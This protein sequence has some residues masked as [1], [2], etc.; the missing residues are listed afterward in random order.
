MIP[1]GNNANERNKRVVVV[2]KAVGVFG[3]NGWLRIYSYTRPKE[4]IFSYSPWLLQFD[5][6]YRE[7]KLREGKIHGKGLIALVQGIEDRTQ[8]LTVIGQDI[9]V[10]RYQLPELPAGEF[11]WCDLMQ[12][13]V[14]T[15]DD[16]ELGKVVAIE[17]TGA[18]DVL[19]VEGEQR[20]LIPMVMDKFVKEVDMEKQRILVDWD[21]G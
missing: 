4:N 1:A 5:A 2:G 10:Y 8:A 15:L 12:Q 6:G 3:V 13:T 19:V 18:N 9:A 21:I 7:R 16:I 14:V 11:Y 20:Y 17:E